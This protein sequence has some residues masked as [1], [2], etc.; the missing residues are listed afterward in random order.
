MLPSRRCRHRS[1]IRIFKIIQGEEQNRLTWT[2][3]TERKANNSTYKIWKASAQSWLCST[4]ANTDTLAFPGSSYRRQHQSGAC[5]AE[6]EW[7]ATPQSWQSGAFNHASN[8][9][10]MKC[11][12]TGKPGCTVGNTLTNQRRGFESQFWHLVVALTYQAEYSTTKRGA[13]LAFIT[14][15]PVSQNQQ[16]KMGKQQEDCLISHGNTACQVGPWHGPVWQNQKC[17]EWK[18]PSK[19]WVRKQN[20]AVYFDRR[21][22]CTCGFGITPWSPTVILLVAC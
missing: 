10:N 5:L 18:S 21:V 9:G 3:R 19:K 17:T 22:I 13:V 2:L 6:K 12:P 16:K 4:S 8:S 15:I 11:L 20:W 14:M 1:T 7:G